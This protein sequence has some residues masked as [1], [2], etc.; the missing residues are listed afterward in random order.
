VAAIAVRNAIAL[1]VHLD[2]LQERE[3][4]AFGPDLIRRGAQDR[5]GPV[6]LTAIAAVAALLPFLVLGDRPGH[7]LVGPLAG[8][9]IGGLITCTALSLLIV[10][11]L[12]ARF[13]G[14]VRPAADGDVGLLHRWTGLTAGAP[15]RQADAVSVSGSNGD[16]AASNGDQAQ[17][18]GQVGARADGEEGR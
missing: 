11:V 5:L 2:G 4:A 17:P 12:Y 14:P 3:G 7:E 9:T 8:A 6:L 10:P 18:P 16:A 13:G 15:G 1:V